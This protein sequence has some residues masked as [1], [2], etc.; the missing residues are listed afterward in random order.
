M[1]N[2]EAPGEGEVEAFAEAWDLKVL[3]AFA[4][5]SQVA[6]EAEEARGKRGAR[7]PFSHASFAP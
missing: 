6:F 5:G 2:G 1:G 7:E 4:F 3:P